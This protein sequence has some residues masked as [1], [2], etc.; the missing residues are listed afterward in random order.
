MFPIFGLSTVS[1]VRIT[2]FYLLMN[3]ALLFIKH[4]VLIACLCR[5]PLGC[6]LNLHSFG[7]PQE[8]LMDF[9]GTSCGIIC[10]PVKTA[11]VFWNFLYVP[12]Y[13]Y[14]SFGKDPVPTGAH[15]M[16]MSSK[17]KNS[18]ME[19]VHKKLKWLAILK[20]WEHFLPWLSVW[21]NILKKNM[22]LSF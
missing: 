22:R 16:N 10:L 1:L 14:F 5:I 8:F 18:L 17:G 7:H 12:K 4:S 13:R 9:P 20:A 6:S 21:H 3:L 11:K 19:K 15:I 2:D